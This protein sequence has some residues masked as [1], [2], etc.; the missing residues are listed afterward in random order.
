M[1]KTVRKFKQDA[2]YYCF[3]LY[4][5]KED[6]QLIIGIQK[7][8]CTDAKNDYFEIEDVVSGE[9]DRQGFQY[10][11]TETAREFCFSSLKKCKRAMLLKAFE[12]NIEWF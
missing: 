11:N 3:E 7:A 10:D 8:K 9:S 6:G 5:K 4:F 1:T 12:G 2:I